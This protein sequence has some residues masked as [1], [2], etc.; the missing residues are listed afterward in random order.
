M[1][2]PG[3]APHMRFGLVV[4]VVWLKK[5]LYGL[6]QEDPWGLTWTWFHQNI[7]WWDIYV[8]RQQE[9]DTDITIVLLLYVDDT[10]IMGNKSMS[11]EKLGQKLNF[12][13]L[14]IIQEKETGSTLINQPMSIPTWCHW[15][16]WN[17]GQYSPQYTLCTRSCHQGEQ[18]N[19]WSGDMYTV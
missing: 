17:D 6:P 10:L 15:T 13:G 1:A 8:Y 5:S 4:K 3:C 11:I 16:F 18:R 12:L 7:L 19:L 2:C 14:D 9:G